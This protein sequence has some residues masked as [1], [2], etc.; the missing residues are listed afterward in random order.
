LHLWFH[1]TYL[2]ASMRCGISAKQ[3]ERELGVTYKTAWRMAYLIRDVLMEQDA[4]PFTRPVEA[5]E[6]YVGGVRRGTPRGRPGPASHKAA[7]FGVVQR[8]G[9]VKAVT[10]PNVKRAT[11]LP[12]LTAKVLPR[13]MV[14][15]TKW[16]PM[17]RSRGPD[18]TTGASPAEK[19]YVSGDVHTNT[20][21][22]F[23]SLTKRGSAASTTPSRL[24]I[25]RIT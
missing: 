9:R 19:V 24:S 18:A 2:M 4:E 23:W 20:I 17:T 13:E 21:E 8:G 10:V 1:A 11:I 15:P 14:Y 22:G 6:T 7:V 12:H 5:D 3:L 16:R 25:F